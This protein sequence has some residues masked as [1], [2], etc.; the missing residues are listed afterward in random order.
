MTDKT[1]DLC[2]LLAAEMAAKE[3]QKAAAPLADPDVE[4]WNA[5]H[6]D[7]P[8]Q[9]HILM[10]LARRFSKEAMVVADAAVQYYETKQKFKQ[11]R[12]WAWNESISADIDLDEPT[13]PGMKFTCGL[14]W[15]RNR[16]I[17][18][19]EMNDSKY[20]ELKAIF[21]QAMNHLN[22]THQV[23]ADLFATFVPE[24]EP[25]AEE[26]EVVQPP[27]VEEPA[28]PEPLCSDPFAEKMRE[29]ESRWSKPMTAEEIAAASAPEPVETPAQEETAKI[30]SKKKAKHV[31]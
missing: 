20:R 9:D 1:D 12:E 28:M 18:E 23:L 25:K 3:T 10:Q 19:A 14:L 5:G 27:A 30:Y 13:R 21:E 11:V 16:R 15:D 6:E 31:F 22:G 29:E 8:A 17:T 4:R 24:A 2:K 7:H 26:A